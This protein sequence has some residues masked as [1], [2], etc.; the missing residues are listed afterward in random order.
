M[1]EIE[2][3]LA[4]WSRRKRDAVSDEPAQAPDR[5]ARDNEPSSDAG[6]DKS[7]AALNQKVRARSDAKPDSSFADRALVE[8]SAEASPPVFDL[9]Q[10]PS[11]ESITA[12]TDIRPFLAR[13]VPE[14]VMRAALRRAWVA[15]PNIRNFVEMAENQWDFTAPD[16][17]PGFGPLLPV[18]N[19]RRLVAE[20]FGDGP[21]QAEQSQSQAA[22]AGPSKP[23][24]KVQESPSGVADDAR[25]SSLPLNVPES[26]SASEVPVIVQ[27]G[28]VNTALHNYSEQQSPPNKVGKRSHGGALPK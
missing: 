25:T 7:P 6:Q 21:A 17:V 19:I 1:S 12:V 16:G 9:S 13:G 28:E 10:L 22:M 14:D 3:F 23:A 2:N 8:Q 26:S 18:D 11:I 4:R 5:A 27:Y 20:T 24:D 15:D